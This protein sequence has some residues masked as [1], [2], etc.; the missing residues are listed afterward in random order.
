MSH[1]G[2]YLYVACEG[3]AEGV[4]PDTGNLYRDPTSVD[5]RETESSCALAA[6]MLSRASVH[7]TYPTPA[8]TNQKRDVQ[9]TAC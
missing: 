9:G 2:M 1:D 4:N 8:I 3:S 5:T 7:L 6:G